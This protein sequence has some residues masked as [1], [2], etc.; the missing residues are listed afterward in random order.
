[1]D[2]RC[3]LCGTEEERHYD[4]V[5]CPIGD[6]K[7]SATQAFTPPTKRIA[8]LRAL[9]AYRWAREVIGSDSLGHIQDGKQW[10]E[11]K[12]PLRDP[13]RSVVKEDTD[14]AIEYLEL[15]GLLERHPRQKWVHVK[16]AA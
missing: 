12:L 15:R 4:G 7:F 9:L 1:M 16:E 3:V 2:E 6:G 8:E 5:Q 14:K 13:L 11:V 10:F